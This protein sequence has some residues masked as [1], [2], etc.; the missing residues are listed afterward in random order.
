M[1]EGKTSMTKKVTIQD[2]A[3]RLNL[4]PATVSRALRDH[5]SIN[6]GTRRLVHGLAGEMGYTTHLTSRSLRRA[7]PLKRPIAWITP[8]VNFQFEDPIILETLGGI[9]SRCAEI[10]RH[11][12]HIP[13]DVGRELDTYREL[14]A[15][16]VV[17]GFVVAN[18]MT[19]GDRRVEYLLEEKVPFVAYYG[20]TP[21]DGD[22]PSVDVAF[23]DA[24]ALGTRHL[25]D[26]GHR[27]IALLNSLPNFQASAE[28]ERGYR[29]ALA[30][31]DV[32]TSGNWVVAG[33]KTEEFGYS[34][35]R[36]LLDGVAAPTGVICSSTMAAKGALA[37]IN[38]RG[39]LVGQDVSLVNFDDNVA[40]S[41][42]AVPLTGLF[43]PARPLGRKVVDFLDRT[44]AGEPPGTLHHLT[45]PELIVRGSTGP[46]PDQFA[47][48]NAG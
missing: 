20:A 4:S 40:G 3:L 43:S 25:L 38:E 6:E 48:A 16:G 42:Y 27:R 19:E 47:I 36:Q 30:E 45:H 9:A 23:A 13:T 15:E 44:I 11:F 22:Y 33:P 37:A 32:W 17:E 7:G 29:A 14:I 31:R 2:L 18:R 21:L 1:G 28:R 46:V 35:M 24:Y 12:L 10:G 5:P 26:L 41:F 8:L 34:A 39:M